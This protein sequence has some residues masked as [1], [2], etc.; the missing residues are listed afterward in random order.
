MDITC[1]RRLPGIDA[2][3]VQFVRREADHLGFVDDRD[4]D[5]ALLVAVLE[6]ELR[7][8]EWHRF[9]WRLGCGAGK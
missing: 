5:L 8:V 3:L 9:R 6:V 7:R 2:A 4:A 1:F